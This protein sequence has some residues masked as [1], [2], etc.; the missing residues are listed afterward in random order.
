[1]PREVPSSTASAGRRSLSCSPSG[2]VAL[3]GNKQ[4][5]RGVVVDRCEWRISCRILQLQ[6]MNSCEVYCDS[7]YWPR[8]GCSPES[9]T[10]FSRTR[11]PCSRQPPG[12]PSEQK[13][14]YSISSLGPFSPHVIQPASFQCMGRHDR[15]GH[16]MASVML[17]VVSRTQTFSRKF[18]ANKR[19]P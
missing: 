13:G 4:T 19:R 5:H 3:V 11:I 15:A 17:R 2:V 1:M 10:E 14:T 9:W 7:L 8:S 12:R 18:S 16:A 6:S